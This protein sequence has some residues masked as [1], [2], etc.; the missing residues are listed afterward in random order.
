MK[1]LHSFQFRN[2]RF[3]YLENNTPQYNFEADIEGS[4]EEQINSLKESTGKNIADLADEIKVGNLTVNTESSNLRVYTANGEV[5][6]FK[7]GTA[8]QYTGELEERNGRVFAE[9]KGESINGEVVEGFTAANYTAGNVEHT[10]EPRVEAEE[11]AETPEE[12][13]SISTNMG[14]VELLPEV[15]PEYTGKLSIENRNDQFIAVAHVKGIDTNGNEVEGTMD[16]SNLEGILPE[17]YQY[18]IADT[19]NTNIPQLINTLYEER[20]SESNA[21]IDGYIDQLVAEYPETD[22]AAIKENLQTIAQEAYQNGAALE[23][24]AMQIAG[25][26]RALETLLEPD[27]FTKNEGESDSVLME[28]LET[29]AQERS[30]NFF[31]SQIATGRPMTNAI[32]ALF[33]AT[34]T[35]ETPELASN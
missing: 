5:E 6:K 33:K 2:P 15:D 7:K 32:D 19:I 35:P 11:R 14:M 25:Q 1:N 28:A 9:V 4:F 3:V 34:Q 17:E 24:T 22:Q 18:L 30:R 27:F 12:T 31:S 21:G 16:A 29:S 23:K 13:L 8:L 10:P 20:L 26:Q